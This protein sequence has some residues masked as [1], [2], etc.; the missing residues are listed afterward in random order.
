MCVVDQVGETDTSW[1]I[2]STAIRKNGKE[3]LGVTSG[4]RRFDRKA[5]WWNDEIQIKVK[6]KQENFKRWLATTD[7]QEKIQ[8]REEYKRAKL[9]AKKAIS[10]AK[11][12]AYEEM[13]KRLD[14]KEGEQDIYKLAKTRAKKCKD[15]DTVKFLK[16]END[17]TL[18]GDK[19]IKDRWEVYF[20]NLFNQ[21]R[22][23][24]TS[25]ESGVEDRT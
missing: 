16:G 14:T 21:G 15:I 11:T 8:K 24:S 13:Y 6:V 23:E 25:T 10:E 1:T 22:P 4:K 20:Q 2:M 19:D 17:Q 9:E 18:L 12:K 3:L 5:W 7:E